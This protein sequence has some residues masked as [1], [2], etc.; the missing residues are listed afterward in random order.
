MLSGIRI[1]SLDPY[2]I[3]KGIECQKA[4]VTCPR[5]QGD[6]YLTRHMALEQMLDHSASLHKEALEGHRETIKGKGRRRSELLLWAKSGPQQVP[7]ITG[8]GQPFWLPQGFRPHSWILTTLPSRALVIAFRKSSVLL[9]KGK[10]Q[11]KCSYQI[12]TQALCTR[13]QL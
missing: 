3:G 2:L 11:P 6:Q 7:G 12:K 9:R 8:P 5:P 10:V 1:N 13:S 4:R